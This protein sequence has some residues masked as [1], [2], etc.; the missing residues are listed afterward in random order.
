LLKRDLKI[1]RQIS[2]KFTDLLLGLGKKPAGVIDQRRFSGVV[3]CRRIPEK[4]NNRRRGG[5][6]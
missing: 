5:I 1:I 2:Y 4:N 6:K 3:R